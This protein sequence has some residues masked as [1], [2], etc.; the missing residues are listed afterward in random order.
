[1]DWKQSALTLKFD[2]NKSW[3]EVAQ[4]L[5]PYF[6]NKTDQQIRE[7]VRG[8]IRSQDAYKK[9]NPVRE[10]QEVV[11]VLSDTHFPFAHPN[12]IHFVEDTFMKHGVTRIIHAGD[13]CDNHAISRFQ[14]ETDAYSAITEYEMALKDIQIYSR[15]FP[16]VDLLLGNH[17]IIPAKQ[18]ATLG[19]P[20]Q[21]LKGTK[22]LWNLPKDWNVHEQLII[23]DVMYE[24]GIGMSVK[25]GVLDRA[26]NNMTSY[27]AGHSHAFGGVQYKSNSKMLIFGLQVGCGVDIDALAFRY[28][29]YNKNRET[30][31]CGIVKSASEAYFI[32][33][34]DRW[35]RNGGK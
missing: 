35:F 30:L 9:V 1:M 20:Q 16:K 14:T 7:T 21:F 18:A 3:T 15:A 23:N 28:G 24:H 32:P 6:P 5:K 13:I 12:F 19:I 8:F 31:G 4:E 10:K 2:Q 17:C 29:K 26:I 25:N 33:M 11:G 34:S 27:V 22:E